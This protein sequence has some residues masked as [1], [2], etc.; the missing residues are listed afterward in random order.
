MEALRSIIGLLLLSLCL[1]AFAVRQRTHRHRMSDGSVLT[2]KTRASN[3]KK[4]ALYPYKN[5]DPEKKYKVPVVMMSFSDCDFKA[6][7]DLQ[8]YKDL[9][10]TKGF[11]KRH[12]AGCV[13]DYFR[14]Q[15]RGKFNV[16][17]DVVGPFKLTSSQKK[18]GSGYNFGDSQI[19]QAVSQAD[20]QLNFSD[21]DWDN[22]GKAEAVIVVFAGY[23]ANEDTTLVKG[24]IWPNTDYYYGSRLDGVEIAQYSA[25]AEIWA[26]DASCGI[27]TI[28]HEFSH[29]LGLPDL[30]PT[31]GKE[32]SVVD[33]WDLMDGGN[34]ADDG[35][36]P[37]NYSTLEKELLGWQ[38]PEPLK[39]S[40]D[41]TE[42][43]SFD[44]SGKAYKI[45]NES[46]PSEYYLIENRQWQG[47]DY[48]LPN[49]GM[50]ITYVDY[51]ESSWTYNSVNTSPSHHRYEYLHADGHDY[52]FFH[53]LYR[54]PGQYGEDG[55]SMILKNTVYPYTDAEGVTSTIPKLFGNTI[56]ELSEHDGLLTFKFT[57]A[58]SGISSLN[59]DAYP[60]EYYDL[61]GRKINEPGRGVYV[62]RYSDG[63]TKKIMR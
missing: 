24:C 34:Y 38:S 4:A 22:D 47:W 6:E 54:K 57:D 58:A 49:H 9:F 36:C 50:L 27:G 13:A 2:F 3:I 62:V 43:P 59:T 18:S 21:Y 61:Q 63:T 8:F 39:Q 14:D 41:I 10:N 5:W 56:S 42:M 35:W 53:H 30:Y 29:V 25:S 31:S 26:N 46:N 33:E 45:V 32:F 15:S 11:N 20:A 12:G 19:I 51:N 44:S 55:R 16:E 48:M 1:N 28:C 17:F 40:C 60:V 37:P 7:H 52:N 23:G